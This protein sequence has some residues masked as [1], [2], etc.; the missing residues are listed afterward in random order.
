M[1]QF[2]R[3]VP[4]NEFDSW[5]QRQKEQASGGAEGEPAEEQGAEEQAA[6]PAGEQIFNSA[7]CVN[8]HTLAAAGSDAQ[9]G[10][11]LGEIS[12]PTRNYIRTSILNPNAE[13]AEG[14]EPDIMPKNFRDELSDEELD[15]LVKYLLGAQE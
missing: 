8:C 15:A 1:R 4:T 9:V 14:F 11:N 13:I 3:V 12:N 7:G 6:G 10:P 5:I 2:V